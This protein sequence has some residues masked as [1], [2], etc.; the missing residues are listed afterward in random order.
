[1]NNGDITHFEPLSADLLDVSLGAGLGAADELP[2]ALFGSYFG[3]SILNLSMVVLR[4]DLRQVHSQS[5][6]TTGI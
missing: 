6:V 1:M 3:S 4:F 2:V 5:A